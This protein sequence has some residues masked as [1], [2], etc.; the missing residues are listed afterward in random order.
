MKEKEEQME[1]EREKEQLKGGKALAEA[2]AKY[3]EANIIREAEKRRKE[4][5]E[6]E[7][8]MRAIEEQLRRDKEERFGKKFDGTGKAADTASGK[9]PLQ[10]AES[11]VKIIKELYPEFKHPDVAENCFKLLRAY[12][13]NLLKDPENEKFR[14][15]NKENKAFV[16]RVRKV[17]GGL[18]FLR[19]VGFVD[20]GNFLVMKEVNA[21]LI[22]SALQL[23]N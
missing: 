21:E 6:S 19:A 7:R 18:I 2:K 13:S 20:E 4:K 17:D 3:E 9:T 11:G 10:K 16:E 12:L 8:A 1:R 15:I 14:K 22:K 23:L 5:L